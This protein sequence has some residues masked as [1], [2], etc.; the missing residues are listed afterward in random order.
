MLIDHEQTKGKDSEEHIGGHTIAVD[1]NHDKSRKGSKKSR[2]N[3]S[4][5]DVA[6]ALEGLDSRK[7]RKE[8]GVEDKKEEGAVDGTGSLEAP[9]DKKRRKGDKTI[10]VTDEPQEQPPAADKKKKRKAAKARD[11]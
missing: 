1:D 9:R 11:E 3:V 7:K 2:T 10:D 4:G 6:T 5:N 8:R